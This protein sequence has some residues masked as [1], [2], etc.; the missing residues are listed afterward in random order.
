MDE[1][2]LDTM[3]KAALDKIVSLYGKAE[4]DDGPTLFVDHHL[5][6]IEAGYWLKTYGSASPDPERILRSLDLVDTWSD[7]DGDTTN[8]L[9]FSL[10]DN[11]TN[12]LI[13][14]RF[15]EDGEISDILMES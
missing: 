4:G 14:V 6:E 11:V 12:Y 9:D 5:E 3:K 7:D 15:G 13:S 1:Q 2:T 8:V 10:P